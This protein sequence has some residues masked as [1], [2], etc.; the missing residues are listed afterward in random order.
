MY[1]TR[2][3]RPFFSGDILSYSFDTI[4]QITLKNHVVFYEN[5][6]KMLSL[7]Q[8]QG[9]VW[10]RGMLVMRKIQHGMFSYDT[11]LLFLHRY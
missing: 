10:G 11:S 7:I 1:K 3:I 4:S 8:R 5:G 9:H 2:K 6:V